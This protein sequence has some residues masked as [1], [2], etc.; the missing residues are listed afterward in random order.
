MSDKM[1]QKIKEDD[2][3]KRSDGYPGRIGNIK[4]T[5]EGSVRLPNGLRLAGEG[6]M[7]LPTLNLN[8]HYGLVQIKKSQAGFNVTNFGLMNI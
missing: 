1:I 5:N 4:F 3:K 6:P 2:R 7:F 8:L